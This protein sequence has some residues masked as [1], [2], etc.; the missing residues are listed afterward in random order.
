MSPHP[1]RADEHQQLSDAEL[2][3]RLSVHVQE[4][5]ELLKE[6]DRRRLAAETEAEM[7][8]QQPPQE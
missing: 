2:Q 3:A 6:V 8:A 4:V 1:H 7:L 5:D